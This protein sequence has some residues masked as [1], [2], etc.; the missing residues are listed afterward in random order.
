M[1]LQIYENRKEDQVVTD[2]VKQFLLQKNILDLID[3]GNYTE[4]YKL[5][6]RL[7]RS[8]L[9]EFLLSCDIKPDDYMTSLPK[10]YLQRSDIHSYHIS[11]TITTIE[12]WAF[13]ECKSLTSVTFGKNSQLTIIGDGAFKG[14]TSLTSITIP[15]SVTNI[16]E[17]AFRDCFSLVSIT[18]PDSVTRIGNHAF[19]QCYNL[20]SIHFGGTVAKWNAISNGHNALDTFSTK[21]TVYCTDGIL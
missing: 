5:C 18:I 6:D 9:T 12:E 21:L 16:D 7:D 1:V 3:D 8:D 2:Q 13:H 17:W 4:V 14:C 10:D 11:P 19:Q 20:T 15:D